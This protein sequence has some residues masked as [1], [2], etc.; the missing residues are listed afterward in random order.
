MRAN[1]GSDDAGWLVGLAGFYLNNVFVF[2]SCPWQKRKETD[3]ISVASIGV[4]E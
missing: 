4:S 1:W 3:G 2:F